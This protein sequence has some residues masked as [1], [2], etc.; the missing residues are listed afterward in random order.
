M[1]KIKESIRMGAF[2]ISRHKEPINIMCDLC[3]DHNDNGN[4]SIVELYIFNHLTYL[5]E[6]CYN[7]VREKFIKHELKHDW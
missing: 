6:D 5:C 2:S 7:E 4:K 3:D 1:P